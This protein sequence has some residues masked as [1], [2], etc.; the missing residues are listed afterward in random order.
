M[1]WEQKRRHIGENDEVLT[2]FPS[3]DN[4]NHTQWQWPTCGCTQELGK[5]LSIY[6]YIWICIH[7]HIQ[8]IYIYALTVTAHGCQT[9][10][11]LQIGKCSDLTEITNLNVLPSWPEPLNFSPLPLVSRTE[12]TQEVRP[13]I[14]HGNPSH[15]LFIRRLYQSLELEKACLVVASVCERTNPSTSLL[16]RIFP[17][18]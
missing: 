9:T 13:R 16:R 3:T 8:Y 6:I 7:T 2:K 1:G 14:Q 12:Y 4:I 5:K 17:L 15:V 18:R 11:M 10:E